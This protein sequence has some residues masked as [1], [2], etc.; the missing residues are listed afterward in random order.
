MVTVWPAAENEFASKN[1]LSKTLGPQPEAA[2]PLVNDQC[3]PSV[4]F[5]VPPIQ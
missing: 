1:T 3:E 4:Q 2:P 5:P